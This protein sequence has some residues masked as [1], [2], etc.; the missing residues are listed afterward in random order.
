V[1]GEGGL[2]RLLD[3]IQGRRRRVLIVGG[4]H[5]AFSVAWHL[6]HMARPGESSTKSPPK[7]RRCNPQD[8]WL[9]AGVPFTG[10]AGWDTGSIT[11]AH[12]SPLRLYY[13]DKAAWEAEQGRL[14]CLKE[15]KS[16]P[17]LQPHQISHS[18][19]VNALGGLRWASKELYLQIVAG[20]EKRVQLVEV[21]SNSEA[22][23]DLEA[24]EWQ[25]HIKE[26]DAVVMACGFG[27]T[28]V[29]I[30]DDQGEVALQ[31]DSIGRHTVDKD[32]LSLVLLICL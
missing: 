12:R 2:Q 11:I 18:G 10:G 15:G 31:K 8:P 9:G 32:Y 29:P 19:R 28:T 5:T 30:S 17:P 3:A 26:A 23:P 24:P 20:R 14:G 13:Q 1:L 21:K 16:L 6:L 25:A 22:A 7:R 4:S 27:M